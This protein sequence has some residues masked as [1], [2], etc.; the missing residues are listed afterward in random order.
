MDG[1]SMALGA[2]LRAPASEPSDN[3]VNFS[4]YL[5]QTLS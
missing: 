5:Q 1:S 4:L 2:L 3:T